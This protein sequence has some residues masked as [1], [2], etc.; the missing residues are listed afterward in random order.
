MRLKLDESLPVEVAELLRE[1]GHD[2]VTVLEQDMA[3]GKKAWRPSPK[4]RAKPKIADALKEEV[5]QKATELVETTLK[6]K[7]LPPGTSAEE[8]GFNYVVDVYTK[9][10]TRNGGVATSTSARST[11]APARE[12]SAITSRPASRGWSTWAAADST[13]PTCGIRRSG[14]KSTRG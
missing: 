7:V 5:T 14:G 6:P 12:R 4:K 2:A 11:T 3:K 13:W 8:H 9:T 10:S 1:A